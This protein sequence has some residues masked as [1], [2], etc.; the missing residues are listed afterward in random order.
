MRC[1]TI[2]HCTL[3]LATV[4]CCFLFPLTV[5]AQ[6]FPP[7]ADEELKMTSE[8]QAPGAP[9]VILFREVDRD[10]N[11]HT[12]HEDNYIR[13]K[14]FT[15]EGRNRANVEIPFNK[16]NEN[17]VNIH[18]R[19]VKPDGSAVNFDGKVFEKTIE[20]GQGVKYI[21]KSFTLPD[22]QIGSIIE[23]HFTYDLSEE[24]IYDSHWT[25][26]EDLFTRYARFT[27]KPYVAK[28]GPMDLRWNWQGLP[29]GA[30]PKQGPDRI[31]RME[32]HNIPAFHEEDY[33]PPANELRAHVN[34]IYTDDI[35]EHEP[36]KFWKHVGKKRN[37]QL[38]S[39]IGKHKAMEEA[40]AQIVSP[41]DPPEVKLRKIYDRVQ[42][43]RNT[44]YE[45]QKTAQE[46]KREKEKPPE[47]V[48]DLWKHGYGSGTDL[49]WLYLALVR[50]A[51]FDACGV[52][53]SS[54][55]N[56]FFTSKTME[57][58]KLNSNLVLVKLNGK[59]I[60]FDPGAALTP[61]GML[62]WY[63]TA[64][65]GLC[66]NKDGGT[67]VTTSLPASKDSRIQ[68][69]AKF[70][71][72]ENGDLQG[73]IALTYTGLEAMY[74]RLEVL[75]SDDVERK[76]FIEERLKKQIPAAAE[77]ELT[78]KPDWTSSETPL[79][80]EF[81]VTI[82]GWASNAGKRA[83]V[84]TGIF[85]EA[86]KH[87]FEHSDRVNP[88]YL[89]YPYEKDDDVTIE[90]PA[91][92]QAVSVP[93]PKTEDGHIVTYSLNVDKTQNSVHMTRKVTW[94]FLL[95][96]SKYYP[97]LRNFF[98]GVRSGDD[99]QIVLQPAATAASN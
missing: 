58:R 60:Y 38:E 40:V 62:T 7:I 92:W 77:I 81:N 50:A 8:P 57:D 6:G 3:I 4:L 2:R 9:A 82:P 22:V 98:Q 65:P 16:V 61:F 47:N 12:S 78:N 27:L 74:N 70:K 79:V 96:E 93:A 67:W 31:V 64:T 55:G 21:A 20:K 45:F 87:T 48:D 33:M 86:E 99:Q 75:R 36:D 32:V 80:A 17:V 85:T 14:I 28:Y 71:L 23:Y 29:Q 63:E 39:F 26:N 37:D 43:V 84:P 46:E 11:G 49:T 10:D 54:R 59:D 97:A 90:L 41:S 5:R 89:Q 52:W 15:E 73:T 68:H 13:I 94:D 19:T 69:T 76:K 88:I 1:A 66:L 56:A 24:Y 83:L 18:G 42:Q 34:F 51:G 35:V 25:L 95:I 30:E 44:S 91:G 72:G 53:A